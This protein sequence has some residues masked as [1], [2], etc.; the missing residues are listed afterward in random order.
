MEKIKGKKLKFISLIKRDGSGTITIGSK[1]NFGM[2]IPRVDD[3]TYEDESNFELCVLSITERTFIAHGFNSYVVRLKRD[4][5]FIGKR[6]HKKLPLTDT[7]IYQIK[8]GSKT[9]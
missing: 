4:K 2:S 3:M 9:K 6:K 8:L 1:W 7:S 5:R